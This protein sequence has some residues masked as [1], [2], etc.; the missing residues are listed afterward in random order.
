MITPIF[1]TSLVMMIVASMILVSTKRE[2]FYNSNVRQDLVFDGGNNWNI[3]T[4][5][6]GRHTMFISPAAKYGT[7]DWNWAN[8]VKFEAADGRVVM[9]RIQLGNKFLLSG[10]KDFA[11]DD[12]W[13]RLS[14]TQNSAYYG[15]FAAGELWA[16]KGSLSGSDRRLKD[17]IEPLSFEIS[18]KVLKLEPRTYEYKTSPGVKRYGFVAQDVEEVLPYLVST[19]P[20]DMKSVRYDD[21]I[22]LLVAQVK[23]MRDEIAEL[24]AKVCVE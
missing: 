6:D 24:K 3:H 21:V 18:E 19:G 2:Y 9:N 7:K 15:G 20:D 4:P 14:N 12:S 11:A 22:A 16:Q 17:H 23:K 8:Q 10:I 5:D 1:L 13:L